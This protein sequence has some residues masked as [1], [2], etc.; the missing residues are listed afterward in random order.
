MA[1]IAN[2]IQL[3]RGVAAVAERPLVSIAF[4]PYAMGVQLAKSNGMG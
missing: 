4:F 3:R 1:P 2:A